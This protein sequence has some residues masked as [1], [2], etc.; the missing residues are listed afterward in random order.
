MNL[1]NIFNKN[2]NHIKVQIKYKKVQKIKKD[3]Q[4]DIQ[5]NIKLNRQQQCE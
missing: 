5:N 4:K 3:I 2:S 1:T